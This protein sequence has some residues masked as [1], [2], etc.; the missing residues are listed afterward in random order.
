MTDVGE[1]GGRVINGAREGGVGERRGRGS[2]IERGREGRV[3][4]LRRLRK[5]LTEEGV[6]TANYLRKIVRYQKYGS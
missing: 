4:G 1:R 3:S 6:F 5:A 2:R